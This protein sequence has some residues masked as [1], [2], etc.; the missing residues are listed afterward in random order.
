[1]KVNNI[2]LVRHIILAMITSIIWICQTG[3]SHA[4]Q[5]GIIIGTAQWVDNLNPFTYTAYP[6]ELVVQFTTERLIQ[7]ICTGSEENAYR[8]VIHIP[9]KRSIDQDYKPL[10]SKFYLRLKQGDIH[11]HDIR[12]TL[13]QI[14]LAAMNRYH[15][16]ELTFVP[17]LIEIMNPRSAKFEKAAAAFTFP[18]IRNVILDFKTRVSGNDH[19]EAYNKATTGV[20]QLDLFE[21]H[22]IKLTSRKPYI[23]A[24]P[25][26]IHV[27]DKW[28]LFLKTMLSSEIHVGL[29]VNGDLK[30]R[31]KSLD[32]YELKE[33]DDLNSFTYFG[34][35]YNTGKKRA[36]KLFSKE[37]EFRQAFAFAV[38][39]DKVIQERVNLYGSIM[40]NTFDSMRNVDGMTPPIK[41]SRSLPKTVSRFVQSLYEPNKVTLRLLCRPG[42]I[43]SLGHM[44]LLVSSLNKTF[45]AANIE[46]Q[47][48]SAPIASEFNKKKIDKDFEIIFD[49]FVYG[50]NKL[51]YIEFMNPVSKVNFLGCEFF[52]KEEIKMYKQKIEMQDRFLLKVNKEL[53]VFVL[54]RFQNKNAVSKQINTKDSLCS[55][56][57]VI[58]FT[59]IH[60]WRVLQPQPQNL[61]S[62]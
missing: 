37:S 59:D 54:G 34:F 40:N 42:L 58:P 43:F 4:N 28:E 26:T 13:D 27:E 17:D 21:P 50:K 56:S 51:R 23:S 44:E 11:M 55:K 33:T 53:P 5:N 2:V 7:Q 10:E 19:I 16:H 35:N 36:Q 24:T 9:S 30:D 29:S 57:R 8:P 52:S 41:Y 32:T 6:A 22:K 60:Q 18:I 20:Y 45:A 39:N 31:L 49:T 48:N 62:P 1:M 15:E 25:L 47:L 61:K 14:K 3:T 12:F 38:A 46:F